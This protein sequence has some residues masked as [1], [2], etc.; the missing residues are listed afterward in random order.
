MDL[1]YKEDWERARR[2][3]DAW[4]QGEVLDRACIKVTAPRHPVKEEP[5]PSP[6]ELWSYWLDPGR[7]I[8]RL[9]AHLEATYWGGEAF[10]VMFPMSTGIPC[11]LAA[12][13]GCR[14]KFVNLFTGWQDPCLLDWRDRKPLRFDPSNDM[15][16]RT[17]QLFRAAGENAQGRYYIGL[18]DLNGPGEAIARLRGPERLAIDLLENPDRVKQAVTESTALWLE[19]YNAGMKVI[20]E[21][22]DGWHY[23]M[24]IWSDRPSTDLQCDFSCMI[25]PAMFQEFFLPGIERQTQWIGRT[26]YHLDGPGAIRHLDALL[27]LPKLTGIQ[28]VPG[29]G[30]PRMGQWIPLL[31]KI[32]SAGKRLFITFDKSELALLLREL[33]PEGLL[34]QTHCD[35]VEE[36]ET[37]IKT[38]EK[39]STRR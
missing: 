14:V 7:V 27:A 6:A 13:M 19:Y 32:Q 10:P 18:P 4:W 31:K 17:E 30:A 21:Y 34:M 29:A 39:S 12:Y 11:I 5:A 2:R 9:S 33:R 20:H 8:P 23:W 28:W 22:V 26:V 24:G 35:T 16:Q 36:V 25:S 38:V 15:W 37:V 1:V 3:I